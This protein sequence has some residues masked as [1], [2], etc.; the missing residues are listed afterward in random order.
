MDKVEKP[1]NPECYTPSSEPFRI[2]NLVWQVKWLSN[3]VFMLLLC[4]KLEYF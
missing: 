4:L 2:T 3:N 1:R